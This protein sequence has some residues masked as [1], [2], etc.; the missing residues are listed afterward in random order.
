M[1][2]EVVK[3]YLKQWRRDQEVVELPTSTATVTLAAGAL[4][5][6]PARIAKSLCLAWK[7]GYGALVVAAGDARVDNQKFKKRFGGSPKMMNP[8]EALRFTGFT[9]GGISPFGLPQTV[10]VYLDESLRRFETVF[11][12]CGSANSMIEVNL[13]QLAEYSRSRD[14][15]DVCRL[16]ETL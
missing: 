7:G 16:P 2:V 8:E 1:S 13:E 9:V 4:G 10:E 14:W 15:V 3:T 12:A 5:V 11:P 6:S